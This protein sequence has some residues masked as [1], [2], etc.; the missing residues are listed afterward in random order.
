MTTTSD[1]TNATATTSDRAN[2][3]TTE[4]SSTVIGVFPTLD[5]AEK[6]IDELRHAQFSYGRIRMVER[7][8]GSFLDTLKG[9]FTGQSSM[10]SNSVD[11]LIKM[12]MPEYEAQHYQS[13]L[14]AHHILV[15]MNAD[16]RP[17][18]A[19]NLMR[20]NGA[21]DITSR[22]RMAPA[23]DVAKAEQRRS[24][25]ETPDS[26]TPSAAPSSNAPSSLPHADVPP[27]TSDSDNAFKSGE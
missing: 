23:N 15:L 5:Q 26:E 14:D 4:P 18:D 2:T 1:R 22:L 3:T 16:E 8:T 19:F 24:V 7:G 10:A 21:F 25:Q 17:E 9:M 27:A 13:E 6:A 20:Q 11:N 12:G